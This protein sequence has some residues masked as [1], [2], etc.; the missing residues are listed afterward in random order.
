MSANVGDADEVAIA[1]RNLQNADIP[2]DY[3]GKVFKALAA[4]DKTDIPYVS[5]EAASAISKAM[6]PMT[7][8]QRE[9]F[10]Y[11]LPEWDGGIEDLVEM[12][13]TV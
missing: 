11:L 9:E 1:F 6:E 12:L 3:T 2:W 8:D 7:P 4:R 13:R 10:L 5:S